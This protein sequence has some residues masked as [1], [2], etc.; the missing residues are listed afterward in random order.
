M[1][2]LLLAATVALAPFFMAQSASAIPLA[3]DG[4]WSQADEFISA[5]TFFTTTW[6]FTCIVG[7]QL[8]VSDWAV[9]SDMF[10]VFDNTVSI[11]LTSIV[12]SWDVLGCAGSFD[13]ACYTADPDAAWADSRYSQG[14]FNLGAGFHSITILSLFIPPTDNGGPFPDSTVQVRARE[15]P[16][17]A[18]FGLLAVGLAGL[19]VFGRR[20]KK[21]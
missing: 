5:G 7:C 1:R 20:R 18:A 4:T 2:K 8:D 3:T 21:A 10:E 17:P 12:P 19:G 14:T 11:G 9:I 15:V 16:I 13:P 6:D